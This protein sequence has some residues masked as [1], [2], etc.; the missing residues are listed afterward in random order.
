MLMDISSEMIHG[1]LPVY[2]VT[3]LGTSTLTVGIIEGVAEATASITK[4]FSGA[5][6]DWLGK[7]KLLAVVGYAMAAMTKPIF[8]LAAT[9]DWLVAAR[10]VDRI[11][12]GIRGAP[13][14]ALVGDIAPPELRGACYGLRQ[15]LD[16]VGA[17]IGPMAAIALMALTANSFT[18]VFWIAVVPAFLAVALL[19]AGVDEPAAAHIPDPKRP[20]FGFGGLRRL[21]RGFWAVLAVGTALA[22]ARFSEA[23]L[24]LRA[25]DIGLSI[26]LAP[27]VLVVMS[28]AYALSAYPAGVLADRM[29]RRWLLAIGMVVLMA[30]DFCLA[31]ATGLGLATIGALLWGLHMGLTQGLL[32]AMVA[33]TAPDDLRGTAFGVFSLAGGVATLAASV[34][35]GALWDEFGPAVTFLGGAVFT[36]LSLL[37]LLLLPRRRDGSG[38]P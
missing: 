34:I 37:G 31:A 33:D 27:A 10:F 5:L 29:S 17:F 12:K 7:R 21:G 26:G 14:D 13:R 8:P 4:V 16:T 1:L 28:M 11:G 9:A 25:Q 35:A 22:I 36:A 24:V 6:S 2:L 38:N 30:A 19:L 23:F 3:V 32:A 20:P 15:S 18:T